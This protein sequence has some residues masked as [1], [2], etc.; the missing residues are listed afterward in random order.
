[1][2]ENSLTLEIPKSIIK[3]FTRFYMK[4]IPSIGILIL[5]FNFISYS[6]SGWINMPLSPPFYSNF[7]ICFINSNTGFVFGINGQ[8]KKTTNA[9]QN[10]FSQTSNTSVHIYESI[11]L[12]ENVLFTVGYGGVMLK[13]TNQGVNWNVNYLGGGSYDIKFINQFTGWAVGTKIFKTTNAGETWVIQLTNANYEWN[14]IYF[15][16]ELTGWAAGGDW[17]AQHIIFQ[18]YQRID[19]TTNGGQNWLNVHRVYSGSG[20]NTTP[21]L[22][23]ITF[24]NENTGFAVGVK[25]TLLKSTNSGLSW[26]VTRLNYNVLLNKICFLSTDTGWIIGNNGLILKTNDQGLNWFQQYSGVSENLL[27]INCLNSHDCWITGTNGVILHTTDGGGGPFTGITNNQIPS[28]YSIF[29]NYP[30]PF[31]T[32]TNIKFDIPKRSNVKI[33]IYDILGKEITVLVN[34]ELNPGTFEV[35]WDASNF[36]SGVYFYK[37]ETEEFSESKKMVLIK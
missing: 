5:T 35:N 1:M 34:E 21:Y 25:D 37:I 22:K 20:L 3:F 26:T 12:N 16:D 32:V 33:S 7:S 8:L 11:A 13:T 36:P 4:I 27:D 15:K 10:W 24:V 23:S 9:G 30:N 29:Q 2:I 14:S 17:I 6:Q 19:K 31:N 28:G 18:S